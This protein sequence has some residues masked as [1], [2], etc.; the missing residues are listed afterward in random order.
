MKFE[1]AEL[2]LSRGDTITWINKDFVD[3]DVSEEKSK[4]WTSSVIHPGKQWSNVIEKGADYF[5]SIHVV[6]KGKLKVN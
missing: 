2:I 5:C 6:M 1:P 3:H 4:T